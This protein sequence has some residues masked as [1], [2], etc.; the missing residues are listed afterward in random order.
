MGRAFNS[1]H[2]VQHYQT[3]NFLKY[4]LADRQPTPRQM[5]QVTGNFQMIGEIAGDGV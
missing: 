4:L 3:A 2:V 1:D 5:L